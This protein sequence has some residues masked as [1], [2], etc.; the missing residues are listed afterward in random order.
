MRLKRSTGAKNSVSMWLHRLNRNKKFLLISVDVLLVVSAARSHLLLWQ[1]TDNTH[2]LILQS[3]EV[4]LSRPTLP[5][6]PSAV[7]FYIVFP[8]FWAGLLFSNKKKNKIRS[9]AELWSKPSETR[10][11]IIMTFSS[12][13]ML[14]CKPIFR[15]LSF[16]RMKL[17]R[18]LP[19]WS[20][21]HDLLC[22]YCFS[23]SHPSPD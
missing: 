19:R 21:S 12:L 15:P 14:P 13:I 20:F 3:E 2:Q 18:Q 8:S 10:L 23:W 5:P 4:H 9:P 7:H 1:R 17:C 16:L 6:L 11:R 22:Y